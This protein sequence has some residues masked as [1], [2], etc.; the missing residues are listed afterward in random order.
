MTGGT[1]ADVFRFQSLADVGTLT[2]RD[3]ITD[4]SQAEGDKIDL[5]AIDA[6]AGGADDAFTFIGT[7]V[8][9]TNTAGQLRAGYVGSL[10]IIEA[11][12]DGNGVA[13]FQIQLT[14]N[15]LLTGGDFNL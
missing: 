14:G 6:I 11:D 2:T 9:F 4:F 1:G 15:I 12:I 3:R 5:S 7:N 13:E 8:A 10:T